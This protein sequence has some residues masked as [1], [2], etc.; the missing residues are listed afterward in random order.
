MTWSPDPAETV[1]E[2]HYHQQHTSLVQNTSFIV[3]MLRT[4]RLLDTHQNLSQLSN[5][6][7]FLSIHQQLS[8]LM[9]DQ[10]TR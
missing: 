4:A 3:Q 5:Q 1:Y 6:E 10:I 2:A 9:S 7:T 8:V